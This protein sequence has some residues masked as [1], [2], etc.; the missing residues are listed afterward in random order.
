MNGITRAEFDQLRA[1]I[2]EIRDIADATLHAIN[3]SKRERWIEVAKDARFYRRITQEPTMWGSGIGV[4][5]RRALELAGFLN[6]AEVAAVPR[7]EIEG[8]D[9][10]GPV[11]VRQI[12]TALAEHKIDWR[13]GY[14]PV[15]EAV[16]A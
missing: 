4:K 2:E 10:V 9:G 3:G 8:I 11:T 13:G 12:E 14:P 15:P 7:T 16:T 1:D 5:A 6:L